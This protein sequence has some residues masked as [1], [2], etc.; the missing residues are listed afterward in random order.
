MEIIF[1]SSPQ[2]THFGKVPPFQYWWPI[3]RRRPFV[4]SKIF[5]MT[6]EWM[7]RG[8]VGEYEGH[9]SHWQWVLP[10][11]SSKQRLGQ[12][13]WFDPF[14]A[15][16]HWWHNMP[17][18]MLAKEH[19]FSNRIGPFLNLHIS[20]ITAPKLQPPEQGQND[21]HEAWSCSI[22]PSPQTGLSLAATWQSTSA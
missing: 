17:P 14:V 13:K 8:E 7:L 20:Y 15:I 19:I 4:Y 3:H 1:L 10:I 21:P 12:D 9:D 11:P 22:F 16:L 5:G 2:F 6:M 18:Q